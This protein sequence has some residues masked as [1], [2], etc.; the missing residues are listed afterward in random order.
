M[1]SLESARKSTTYDEAFY[2]SFATQNQVLFILYRYVLSYL[3]QNHSFKLDEQDRPQDLAFHSQY[4]VE[5]KV[6]L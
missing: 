1:Y 2:S 5:R 6:Y 4:Q 3:A